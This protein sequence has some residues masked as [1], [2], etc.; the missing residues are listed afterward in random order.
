MCPYYDEERCYCKIYK[1]T[2]SS[3]DCKAYCYECSYSYRDCANY[4]EAERC[5]GVVPPP[6]KYN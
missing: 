3:Y 4:K 2:Q 1:T 5:Y 6:Y